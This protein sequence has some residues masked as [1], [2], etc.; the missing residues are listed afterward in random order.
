MYKVRIDC[1]EGPF[2]LLVY[3]LENAKMDI[4]DIRVSEITEQYISY[5]KEMEDMDIE[6]GS[7]FIVLA[8]VLVRL[9]SHM[10]LPRVTEAG[11]TVIDEDP[12]MQ[13]ATRLAEYVKIKRI[14]EMLS[15]REEEYSHVHEKPGEDISEYIEEPEEILKADP[16][17]FIKAFL[18]FLDK[19]KAVANVRR[20]YERVKR[21]RE[22]I[23]ERITFIGKMLEEKLAAAGSATFYE[24]IPEG[25][26]RYDVAL[27]FMS[28][29][30]MMKH[31]K[32]NVHQN[33]VYGEIVIEPRREEA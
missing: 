16:D 23:D 10:L 27:S 24:L 7:E 3:L 14:A 11:E 19:K 21:Q 20:R 12:R 32:I 4:Y 22:S 18:L 5:L 13:L 30:E 31:E 8:A 17:K 15:E 29:L 26:D 25:G 9:K 28:L 33:E 2:D 1:F 6:V